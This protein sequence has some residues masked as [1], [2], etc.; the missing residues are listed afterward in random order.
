MLPYVP[1][2]EYCVKGVLLNALLVRVAMTLPIRY[3]E[4]SFVQFVKAPE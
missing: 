4:T 1:V 2:Y 3:S